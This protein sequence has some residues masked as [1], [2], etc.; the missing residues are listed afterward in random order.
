MEET[1][2]GWPR[3]NGGA[4]SGGE[5]DEDHFDSL[6][7][8]VLLDVFNHIGDVKALGRCALVSRR[9]HALVPLVD[10]VLVRVD[11]VIPDDPPPS[12]AS[13]SSPPPA[14]ARG[15]GALAHIARFLLGGIVRPIQALGQTR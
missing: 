12:S 8:A 5:D 10:S 15:R 1:R 6:P 3:A 13:S 9:F 14:P 7:D 2:E 11:C 4:A